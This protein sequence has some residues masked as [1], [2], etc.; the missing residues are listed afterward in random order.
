M[1]DEKTAA[2]GP[3]PCSIVTVPALSRRASPADAVESS[4]FVWPVVMA[5]MPG[6]A[7]VCVS[8]SGLAGGVKLLV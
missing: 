4:T 6:A 1:T 7:A 3:A 2:V 5:L 8:A